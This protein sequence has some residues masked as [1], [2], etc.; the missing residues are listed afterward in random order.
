[1]TLQFD[2][3][4]VAKLKA[5]IEE[6]TTELKVAEKQSKID[7]II[8]TWE[9]VQAYKNELAS[10]KKKHGV[11]NSDI[12]SSKNIYKYHKGKN[13]TNDA[14]ADWVKSH[15]DAGG[16][17]SDLEQNARAFLQR[18]AKQK[19]ADIARETRKRELAAAQAAQAEKAET[20]ENRTSKSSDEKNTESSKGDAKRT[21][22]GVGKKG[23]RST[24]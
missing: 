23:I 4:E 19:L 9:R 15:I 18:A 22:T 6:L 8:A 2:S 1:M 14:N 3:D 5:Q 7:N 20:G 10:L 17:I 16:T 21:D 11:T 12:A 13:R 24:I